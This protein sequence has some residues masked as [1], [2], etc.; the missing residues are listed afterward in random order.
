MSIKNLCLEVTNQCYQ[1]CIHCSSCSCIDAN[2]YLTIETINNILDQLQ[3]LEYVSI[4]G[5]EPFLHKNFLSIIKILYDRK[6]KYCIY[7]CGYGY[8][9]NIVKDLIKFGCNKVIFSLHGNKE[10]QNEISRI[11]SYDTTIETILYFKKFINVELHIVPMSI[12]YDVI[13]S[14]VFFARE[15]NIYVSF[16]KFVPQGRAK[17]ELEL[18]KQQEI[19]LYNKY[20]D[21]YRFGSPFGHT[22]CT[23]AQD[24]LLIASDGKIIPCEAFKHYRKNCFDVY[25]NKIMDVFNNSDL[26]CKLRTENAICLG[27]EYLNVVKN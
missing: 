20:K 25:S 27:R 24:K 3:N 11:H 6:L 7:S 19:D 26:F 22:Q 17:K 2:D 16:L 9:K 8:D 4:F 1:N 12:N 23:V 5:G 15:H 21:V 18:T 10:V 14:I 13:D